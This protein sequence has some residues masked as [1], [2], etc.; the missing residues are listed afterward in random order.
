MSLSVRLARPEDDTAWNAFV[1]SHPQG[2][3]FHLTA[4]RDCIC[5]TFGYEPRLLLAEDQGQ[6][7]AVL[8]LFLIS[9]PLSGRILLS[10]PFAV[11]GGVLA[12]SAEAQQAVKEALE[13]MAREQKVQY[14]ELRNAWP[15]QSLGCH[16]VCRY[17]TFTQELSGTEE[18][19]LQKIP[20]KTRAAIRKSLQC[21]L[22]ARR[23]RSL[24]AFCRLYLANLK[25]LGTP[26][27][28][29][30]HFERLLSRYGDSCFVLEVLSEGTVAAAVMTF[31]FRGQVMPY[32]GAS[33]PRYHALQPNNFMY[34]ELM[35]SGLHEGMRL[36]DFGRSKIERSGSFDFKSHWGMTMR[37]LP[38]E[39]MLVSRRD[40]P[41]LSP[42]NPRFELFIQMWRRLPLWVANRVGPALIKWVP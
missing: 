18:E 2:T 9:S 10:S 14:V 1:E 26:A 32:Y 3:P 15:E 6:I 29:R 34:W 28:P 16:P 21:G 19:L 37:E 39:V 17:V 27:F 42:N 35:R 4:W 8:P 31:L 41:D 13:Q 5:E 23:T 38:Y 24:D 30:S 22:Q 11:Y 40:L 20:R 25:R 12:S 33:D 36:F 7:H